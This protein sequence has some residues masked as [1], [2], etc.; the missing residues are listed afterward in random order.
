VRLRRIHC[1]LNTRYVEERLY[2]RMFQLYH[3][4]GTRLDCIRPVTSH[5]SGI[6]LLYFVSNMTGMFF[7]QDVHARD[8]AHARDYDYRI[9]SLIGID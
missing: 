2:L 8:F 6:V 5:R 4:L 9:Y 7:Q 1:T 3:Y